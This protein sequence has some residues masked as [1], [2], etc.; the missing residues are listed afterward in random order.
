MHLVAKLFG[1]LFGNWLCSKTNY[2][3][4]TYLRFRQCPVI[5]EDSSNKVTQDLGVPRGSIWNI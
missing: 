1:L 3:Y 2:S 5:Q 4:L